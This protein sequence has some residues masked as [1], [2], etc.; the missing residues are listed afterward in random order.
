ML[1]RDILEVAFL[2]DYFRSNEARIAE[3][4]GCIESGKKPEIWRVQSADR[5]G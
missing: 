2:L 5:S 3:W 4:R 1:Q